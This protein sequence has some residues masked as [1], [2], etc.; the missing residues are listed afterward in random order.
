MLAKNNILA[1]HSR[2]M[3]DAKDLTKK[4]AADMAAI[5]GVRSD[6]YSLSAVVEP[7]SNPSTLSNGGVDGEARESKKRKIDKK[8]DNDKGH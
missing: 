8:V 3:R 4:S 2:K 6:V 1:G 5:F 7:N